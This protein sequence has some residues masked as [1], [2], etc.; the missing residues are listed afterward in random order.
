[1][2][3]LLLLFITIG[4]LSCNNEKVLELPEINHSKISEI[5]DISA[6]YLFYDSEK[7]SIELNRKNLI[8]TTNWLVNVDKRLSLKLAIPQIT[9]LQNK[10]K[11]AGHKKEGIKNYFTCNDTSLKSL[12]FIEFTETVYH[13]ETSWEYLAKLS[14]LNE[15]KNAI[16]ITF[17]NTN[18]ISIIEVDSSL[19]STKTDKNNLLAYLKKQDRANHNIYLNFNVDLN[20]QDYITYKSLLEKADL[21]ESKISNNEFIFN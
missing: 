11:N 1:M 19:T 2:K 8:S 6:A 10:K 21:K 15:S 16:S 9:F 17:D 12:G 4:L 14:D 20:F 13:E 7:D 3:H 18:S 5:D